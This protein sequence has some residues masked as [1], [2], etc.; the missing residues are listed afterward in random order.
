M[1]PLVRGV[2]VTAAALLPGKARRERHLE[3]WLADGEGAAE[4]GLTSSRVALGALRAALVMNLTRR[5]AVP[6]GL[7]AVL[8]IGGVRLAVTTSEQA[9]GTAVAMAGVAL[10]L[11]LLIIR[12]FTE[13]DWEDT[14][15]AGQAGPP[16]GRK[17]PLPL[18]LGAVPV[19]LAALLLLILFR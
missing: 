7:A 3:Q 8:V 15:T 6:L 14:L 16:P 9:L 4:A 17:R 19:I 2:I 12:R 13:R 5:S 1:N 10:P 11:L 18:I